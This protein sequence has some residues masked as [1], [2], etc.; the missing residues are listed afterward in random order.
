MSWFGWLWAP[1]NQPAAWSCL[2]PQLLLCLC[3]AAAST[4]A[5]M[6]ARP[7]CRPC[8]AGVSVVW[9]VLGTLAFMI[10]LLAVAPTHQSASYVFTQFDKPGAQ[11]AEFVVLAAGPRRR[12]PGVVWPH[13]LAG[14]L[15]RSCLAAPPR[16]CL[17]TCSPPP[18]SHLACFK[19]ALPSLQTWAS[20]L[21]PSSSCWACSCP[22][23]R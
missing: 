8:A 2:L 6:P 14:F 19:C 18:L 12:C 3:P 15:E 4:P 9:H 10:A 20:P 16:A 17:T 7:P 11:R 23:S 1:C 21:A 5:A 22:A 13:G